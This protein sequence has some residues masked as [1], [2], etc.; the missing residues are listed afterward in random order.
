MNGSFISTKNDPGDVDL[1]CFADANAIDCLP[2]EMQQ[3]LKAL[4]DGK[5][6]RDTHLCDAYFCP[7]LPE[8]DPA[9]DETRSARKYWMGEFGFDRLDRPKG[10]V[11]TQILPGGPR[12]DDDD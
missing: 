8:T 1:V 11:R 3:R 12:D 5:A 9:F 4:V 7:T 10:I 6:T 2:L